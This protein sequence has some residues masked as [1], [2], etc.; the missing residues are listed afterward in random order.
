MKASTVVATLLTMTVAVNGLFDR[1]NNN[2][3]GDLINGPNN[4]N[5]NDN[6]NNINFDNNNNNNNNNDNDNDNVATTCDC[7]ISK[8]PSGGEKVR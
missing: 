6:K 5:D 1:W 8:C 4:N 7:D 3:K 2:E